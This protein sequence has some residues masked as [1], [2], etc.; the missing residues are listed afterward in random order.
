MQSFFR[1][2]RLIFQCVGLLLLVRSG[3]VDQV[4]VALKIRLI[5]CILPCL[6]FAALLQ[7][8][9]PILFDVPKPFLIVA[10]SH[11]ILAG[12]LKYRFH[13]DVQ[14][15]K[16]H[17]V[18]CPSPFGKNVMSIENHHIFPK[19]ALAFASIQK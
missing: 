15:Q 2:V 8:V 1:K 13:A 12:L 17:F 3:E 6:D 14:L 11:L 4:V 7:P 10:A 19:K 9:L 18:Q 5:R 16:E